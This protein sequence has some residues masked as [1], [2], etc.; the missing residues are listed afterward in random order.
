MLLYTHLLLRESVLGIA[1]YFHVFSAEINFHLDLD[2]VHRNT[3]KE[4]YKQKKGV[5][6]YIFLYKNRGRTHDN[7]NDLPDETLF[8]CLM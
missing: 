7:L 5:L 2:I 1:Q 6:K 8:T 4:Y 3:R